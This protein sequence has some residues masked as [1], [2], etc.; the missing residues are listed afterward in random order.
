MQAGQ[1]LSSENITNSSINYAKSV[2]EG[3]INQ[4]INDW[5]N[6]KGTARVSV[7]SDSKISGDMLLPVIGN[8]DSLLFTQLGMHG[9]EDRNTANLGLGYRQYIGDWMYGINTFYDYDYTG[10]NARLGAGG[11]AWT[12]YLKLAVNGY[13]GLTGWHQSHLSDMKDYD[14]R[15]ANGFDLRAEAYLPS[16]PQ[17]GANIKYEQYF[18]KDIDLG[19]GTDP[20]DLKDNP[21]ALTVGLNYTPVPLI[22]LK[23]EHSVGDKNESL[24]GLDVTYRFGVP[25]EQQISTDSVDS[26]R[27]LMGSMYEFVDRNYEIVMQYRKQ[28]LLHISLPDNVNAKAAET[29]VLPLTVTKAKYGLKDV[30][31]SASP[32]FT[33]NGG[34][35]RKLSLTQLEVKLPAYVYNQRANAAQKYIIKAVGVDNN[36]NN[37]NTAAT[38]INVAPSKNVISELIITPTGSLPA[39]NADYF[40]V[41]AIVVNE[42]GQP[43]V[44]EAIKFNID[45]LKG[46]DGQSAATL[47][48]DGDSNSQVLTA[49]TDSQG[50]ATIYVRSK[51][52]KEGT[53]TATMT[54]GNNMSGRVSFVA[55]TASAQISTLEI[56]NNKALA[57]G[58]STNKLKVTVKD[59][60]GNTLPNSTVE[61]S[62]SHGAT[63]VGGSTVVTDAEG[64]ATFLVTNLTVGDSTITARINGSSKTQVVTF[65]AD[66]STS[67]I[68]QGD[69]TATQD[70][71]ANGVATNLITAKITDANANTVAGVNVSFTVSDGA[72]ITTVRGV[73]GDDG[74]ATATV[75]SLKVGTYTVT[76]RIQESGHTAQ[77]T[78]RFIPDNSTAI[79]VDSNMTINPNGALA[80]GVDI[81]AVEVIVTDAN[82]NLLPNTTV[83]FAVA[84]GAAI[85]TLVG[86]TGSD[87]K[88]K[89]KVTSNIA[90]KFKVTATVSGR[91]TA[92]DAVFVADGS[93]ATI[94]NGSLRVTADNALANGTAMNSVQAKVTDSHGNRVP[95][96][97]VNFT[98]NHSALVTVASAVTDADGLAT[99]TLTNTVAGNAIVTATINGHS[100][101][102]N[103]N[104]TPDSSTATI[105]QSDLRVT[106][107]DAKADGHDTNTVQAKVTDTNGNVVPNA[108]IRFSATNGATVAAASVT[109][110]EQGL[111][112]TTLTNI[113]SGTSAVTATIN[114]HSPR[115]NTNFVADA[116]TATITEANLTVT[117][118]NAKADG[119]AT[120]TV[121]AKVTDANGNIVPNTDVIFTANHGAMITTTSA[122]TNADGLATTTLS[123]TLTGVAKVTATINDHSQSID[124]HFVADSGTATIASGALT[125]T[126][127][128]AKANGSATNAVQAKVTDASGN[129]VPNVIVSFSAT[130]GATV[131]TTSALTN[132]Q[133]IASTTLLSQTAGVSKVTATINNTH[134]SVDTTFIADTSTATITSSALTVTT[135]NAKAD[136]DETNAVQAKVT[137]ASGNVVPNVAVSFTANNGATVISST[138]TTNAQGLANASLTSLTAGVSKVTATIN[139]HSQSVN[140]TFTADSGTAT[141]ISGAL[142][143]VVNNAK[144]NGTATNKVQAKVTDANG[145]I[146]PNVAVSFMANNGAIIIASATTNSQGF[147]TTTLTNIRTGISKV[148]ATINGQNQSVD[149]TFVP[150]SGTATL[151]SGALT[152]TVDNAKANGTATNA[153]QAKVTDAN[154]NI[155]P[156]VVVSFTANNGATIVTASA[157]TNAQGLASTTLTSLTAGISKVTA[158]VN[159]HSQSVNTTFAADTSTATIINGALTVTAD[160]AKANGSATNKVQAKITD[161]NGNVV[162][163]IAV[164]FTANNSATITTASATTNAQGIATTS[165][166]S[167]KAGISKVTATINGHAQNVN[168]TFVSDDGTATIASG[169]LTVTVDNAKANGTATNA[170]EA[171]VTDAN[172]NVLSNV[173]VRF[174]AT[175]GASIA[176]ASATTNS[177]GIASTTLTS[178][179]S[180][181]SKVTATIN[182]HSQSVDTTFVP[183]S[184]TATIITGALTVT[185]DNAKANGAAT[186]AVQAKVTDANG[187]VLP[188]IAVSFT[189]NNGAAI[190]T[191]SSTTNAQGLASTTLTNTK[192]GISKV[193]ATVNG[194]SQSVNTTFVADSATAT[195]T[196]A[197]LIVTSDYAKSDGH[198]TN[199]V[200]AKVTDA[201]GN[202]VPNAAVSFTA[203]NGATVITASA[204]SDAQGLATTTLTNLTAGVSKVTATINGQSQTVNTTF[205]ADDGTATIIDGALT[206]TADNAKAN[207]AATNA[208]QA[209]VTDAYGNIVPNV[210]VNFSAINGATVTTA[211]SITNAQGIAS[212]TL[213][214][215]TAGLSKVTAAINGNRQN[216]NVTFVA[217]SSTATITSGSLAVTVNNA[218]ANGFA[219]NGVQAKVTDS[220]G[221]MV[222][223]VEVSFAAT[224]GAMLTS[225][226]VTTDSQGIANTSLTNTKAGISKVT[227][228]I[229]GHSQSVDTN[230]VA[231]SGTATVIDGALTVTADNAKAN[232]TATNAVQAKVTDANGNLIP[233]VAVSFS[234][235]N[236]ATITRASVT[237]NAQGIASTTLTN[238][239]SGVSKVT[240]TINEH[241]QAVD[242]TFVA[243]STTATIT[244][245]ALTVT[246]NNAKANGTA[247]NAVQAKVTDVNG[248]LVPNV[249]ISFTATNGATVT[250]ASAT[251]NAQGIATTTLSN[252]TAGISK[253]TATINDHS[254]T[255]DTTFVADSGTATII[256]GALTVTADNAK[257]DGV[258]TN[259]VQAKITD[260]SGN[261]VP[262]MTV[263]FSATN[264]ARVTT[265]S[266]TTNDQGIATTT[267]TDITAGISKVTATVSG[268]SQTVNTT[269][270]A[271][272]GTATIIAGALMVVAN[273]AIANG[274]AMNTVQAK[275]TDANGNL[276]PNVVVSFTA[277]NDATIIAASGTTNAQGV[278]S[279]NLANNKA[280]ITKVTATI[281]GHSQTVDTTFVADASTATLLSGSLTITADNAKANG[282]AT[283]VVQAK[284]TDA[285]GNVV[286]NVT[287]TFQR[288]GITDKWIATNSQGIAS[289][290][291]TSTTAGTVPV[292]AVLN[293][294]RQTVNTTFIADSS[295]ASVLA[296]I[297][298]NDA[299]ANG[300][301]ANRV[302]AK[303]TDAHRNVVPNMV[304]NFTATNGARVITASATT[305]A[306]GLAYT[307]LTNTTAGISTVT[308][309]IS[310]SSS[311]VATSFVGDSGTA[312]I[313]S[314]ALTVTADNAKANSLAKNTVQA[315]VTDANGNLVSGVAVSF[316]ATNGARVA[317]SVVTTNAQGIASNDLTSAT[318]GVAKVTATVN[319]HSQTVDTTFVADSS[320]ATLL[321]GA[322][323]ITADNAKANGAATNAVQ[324]K[325]TDA[326]G[327]LVPNV[328]V[329][330]TANNGATIITSATTNAQGVA[331]TTLTS[332][333]AGISKVTATI[334]GHSQTVDTTFVADASTANILSGALTVTA[335]NAKANG[336]ATNAVQAKVT[337]ANGNLV[338]NAIVSFVGT[339]GAAIVNTS[340]VTNT[341]GIASTTLTNIKTG[342]SKVTATINAHSQSVDTNFVAD[343]GTATLISGALTVTVN[344]AKANGTDK[345]TVQ[346]KVT[347]ANGNLV[348]N[349]AVSFTAD[350][351]ATIVATPVSTNAQ[352][353][354][355]TTL[356]NIKTGVTKVTATINGH[357]QTVDTTFIA[358]SSTST[359]V[360]GNLT[361]TVN[362]A[363]ANGVA[364]DT[365]QAKVTDA[366]GNLVP[367]VTV[368]FTAANGAR[369]TTASATTNTQGLATTTLTNITAGISKV[370]ATVNGHSQSVDTTFVADSGT[371]TVASGA[372]TVTANN[373]KANALAT[374]AVQ[375]KITDANG[376][377]VP[378]V[379][380]SFTADNGATV[381]T[382]SA[383]TNAQGIATT[384]LTSITAGIS[385]VTAAINGHSQTVNTTFIADATTA[386]VSTVT[387]NDAV[388][389]KIANTTDNFTFTALVKDVHGNV[390]PNT[391]VTWSQDKGAAV[392]LPAT[393][394]TDA[395]GK[396]TIILTSTKTETLQIQ[397]MAAVG[398]GTKVNADKKVSFRKQ[399]VNVHGVTKNAI[400]N[401]MIPNA[402][403]EI[404]LTPNNSNPEFTVTSGSDGKYAI[405]IPQGSYYLKVTATGFSPYETTLDIQAVTD[406][407]KD[408]VLSPYL[409]GKAARIV[410]TWDSSPS[411][412]D[413]HLWVP[414]VDNPSS[415]YEVYYL[416]KTPSGADANLDVD[417]QAGYGPETIT[418]TTMHSGVYCYAV[419]RYSP[420]PKAYTGAKVKLYLSDG[421]TKEFK[422]EDASGSTDNMQYW[423]VF[424]IDT[425]AGQTDVKTINTLTTGNSGCK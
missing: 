57:D 83:S 163:N 407:Q 145:N 380:V 106:H 155:V 346:A 90:G 423:T 37:S 93:T 347:D 421:S 422:I 235:T 385:K 62:A 107:N 111:A 22:T 378:N 196:R 242:T 21:K 301:A 61:L 323:T 273:N 271:D 13:Y 79:I 188:N 260:A 76:A 47:F 51:L 54:N 364:T 162:P 311:A 313:T 48:K 247:T 285:N 254:Q 105:T 239:K 265:A 314:G 213:T 295:T 144:A 406:Q 304:V 334:N 318:A 136:G 205:A 365:V 399:L 179:K 123:N 349:A 87:G 130:H 316:A 310:G 177:Q 332:K 294:A 395:T 41:T 288:T 77:T 166:T 243:D 345:N 46:N 9:N 394:T 202:V 363:K 148:T 333:V 174:A 280:G 331:T 222:P 141:L 206:I 327:N 81:D 216:V 4:Q 36:G 425:T 12:D 228:T 154:G 175:N 307:T 341:Q 50:K 371:A 342:V 119:H 210:T 416:A 336:I 392:T 147:A 40:T 207:G 350:N 3:L 355:I 43:M 220:N 393:S 15:P 181:I 283:N 18:G 78:T 67:T 53:I 397:V 361:V 357:S 274:V 118:D 75:T 376:N 139:N 221:N 344:N 319:N 255:V 192:A 275:V 140:T 413:G 305:D 377:V 284:V 132:D 264:G 420:D 227:A 60:N 20:D 194:H 98:A 383:T 245:G 11:E 257:A 6:Q 66:K 5:L 131:N 248:N 64:Q 289:A 94:T 231:D 29:I 259:A 263:S 419:N 412:M 309:T 238:I 225:I 65:V 306:T 369:I 178:I 26:L 329:S 171:K 170:V 74:I 391:V 158:T 14:E 38:T 373:A 292:T 58:Q 113:H 185:T 33:A 28:D 405:S 137:D 108:I 240:A 97:T 219:S 403:I 388:I 55:D 32:E 150:D 269:F 86:T 353:L 253:V 91:S 92:K 63:L 230:F 110:D 152:V 138:V 17:L 151:I 153:V 42:Q 211:S 340:A 352:G 303:V 199:A 99:T 102:V 317:F 381:T 30:D 348:P 270:V 217:D 246:A 203:D 128:N 244:S 190:V 308:A 120:D 321:N 161:A 322:L 10:K 262:N 2:G 39:N 368:S 100:Q 56:I 315:K 169:A 398:S 335:D 73:T 24:I 276:V 362:N 129:V 409:D 143:V 84:S 297:V 418:V 45:D 71:V 367:N 157:T 68:T 189:A 424:K 59:G 85:T 122:T 326:N 104:F 415:L 82:A 204:S 160:N 101:N 291:Y 338:P 124:T 370:T 404:S 103:T 173:V 401:A 23:G 233:D 191:A 168:V 121:L 186:N 272:G 417:A 268:H 215:R 1:I 142:T 290:A 279:T 374:N 286:P 164:A 234:A 16:Y 226:S 159:G 80:N 52:A 396:A 359:L 258:A 250:T 89:A 167:L 146:V 134:Q 360:S 209:K 372:L 149:T 296:V 27:S 390:V 193:T 114:G 224:N 44:A 358:D 184:S 277:N 49:N 183:D 96:V 382:A 176:I 375:A 387:L 282:A 198:A 165:V 214:S 414:K 389:E 197:N 172:G 34:T 218:K 88:A 339:N 261:L 7:T 299:R 31:W 278:A 400:N 115:V 133:G 126:A 212:T 182:G 328:A 117:I 356:T 109:T 293:T 201:N 69:L 320:T 266:A 408:F 116:S 281:N 241:R 25:W 195:I 35:F 402:K 252:L 330:F 325:V 72:R 208:V 298:D 156:N 229:N 256:A 379:T 70:A 19:T 324:A 251:T 351:G 223:N 300:T 249:A 312:T 411:D 187:N 232:G 237:T 180:G 267:L 287:V 112:S 410:L 366:N 125:V 95:N 302:Q 337:D 384:T 236:G 386:N 200:Q 127:D 354:A 135:D 8:N 343:S